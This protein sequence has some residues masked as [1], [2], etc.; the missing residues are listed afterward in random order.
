MVKSLCSLFVLCFV[1]LAGLFVHLTSCFCC[2]CVFVILIFYVCVSVCEA[3]FLGDR[4][5]VRAGT[6]L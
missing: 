3:L 4:E 5:L 2:V 6:R 1:S